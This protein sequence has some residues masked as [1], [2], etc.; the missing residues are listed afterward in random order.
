MVTSRK[1]VTIRQ[2]FT[3]KTFSIYYTGWNMI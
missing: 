2:T 1:K 3:I